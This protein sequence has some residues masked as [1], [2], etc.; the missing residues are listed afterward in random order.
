MALD[1][2]AKGEKLETAEQ[3]EDWKLQADEGCTADY[4]QREMETAVTLGTCYQAEYL[5][6]LSCVCVYD[7]HSDLVIKLN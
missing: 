7:H 6:M 2:S 4:K 1:G 5:K 3:G